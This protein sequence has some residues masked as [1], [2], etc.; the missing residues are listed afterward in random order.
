M[1][2]ALFLAVGCRSDD[3]V[4]TVKEG[5]EKKVRGGEAL[6]EEACEHAI[7]LMRQD[8]DDSMAHKIDNMANEIRRERM[9]EMRKYSEG[10]SNE[11]AR[12][13]IGV[14]DMNQFDKCTP[15]DGSRSDEKTE[16][17]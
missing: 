4:V 12:C 14:T 6:W 9:E 10:I 2:A 17:K 8:M 13:I 15:K 11:M 3:G 5:G 7:N 1:V 16:K